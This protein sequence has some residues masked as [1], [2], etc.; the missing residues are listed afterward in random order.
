ML[1]LFHTARPEA[2]IRLHAQRDVHLA[3]SSFL[4]L[5][6]GNAVHKIKGIIV[7][8]LETLLEAMVGTGHARSDYTC[9]ASL[10]RV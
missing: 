3:L 1:G 9:F 10:L 6:V 7:L 2:V 8:P 4:C 5:V